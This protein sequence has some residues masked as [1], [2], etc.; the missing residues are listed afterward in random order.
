MPM[1]VKHALIK[2]GNQFNDSTNLLF[3]FN[4]GNRGHLMNYASTGYAKTGQPLIAYYTPVPGQAGKYIPVENF[5]D[6]PGIYYFLPKLCRLLGVEQ[7][8][9]VVYFLFAGFLWLLGLLLA[10]KGIN[11]LFQ[12]KLTRRISYALFFMFAVLNIY[13]LDVYL[14][15]Y[16]AAASLPLIIYYLRKRFETNEL[17]T[18]KYYFILATVGIFIGLLNI[19][20]ASTGTGLFLF[21]T[22]FILLVPALQAS[23]SRKMIMIGIV[24]IS[25]GAVKGYFS[26]VES[27]RD[28]W[29]SSQG[30]VQDDLIN[31]H[32]FWHPM[33]LG[34]GYIKNNPYHIV[35]SDNYAFAYAHEVDPTVNASLY[36]HSGKYEKIVKD[37]YFQIL[38]SDPWFVIKTYLLKALKSF[39]FVLAFLNVGLI[40]L[41]RRKKRI[42]KGLTL[43]FI[44]SIGF[45]VLPGVL[46]W[47]FPMYINGALGMA[48]ILNMIL[49]D[50]YLKRSKARTA[51]E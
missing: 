21:I 41:F 33:F 24:V 26:I 46:V 13:I 37:R 17:S 47:P 3:F 29:M 6:D 32:C 16:L 19:T 30:I 42:P 14:A 15:G 12:D 44:A 39:L 1:S 35:W 9:P 31:G 27:Q 43:A 18:R 8:F 48:A 4:K 23:L 36:S 10:W 25:W 50:E 28:K 49:L 20:R 34:L 51:A 11:Y 7:A 38:K 5:G 45:Y 2:I 22:L 40:L